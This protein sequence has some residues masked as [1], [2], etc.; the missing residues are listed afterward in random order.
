VVH[1]WQWPRP[2]RSGL[3]EL[4][5]YEILAV[6]H[7]HHPQAH[8]V[9]TR[10]VD[11]IARSGVL[12]YPLTPGVVERIPHFMGKGLTGYDAAY[13]AVAQE[14]KGIWLTFD[15]RAHHRIAGEGLSVDLN[16]EDVPR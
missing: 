14:M 8:G 16:R 4:F 2:G 3:A 12:R 13:A 5:L 6:L 9:Y 10:Q 7:R 11:R 15:S 1:P